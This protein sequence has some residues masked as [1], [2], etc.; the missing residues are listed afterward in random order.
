MVTLENLYTSD[1]DKILKHLNGEEVS[2][3]I[4]WETSDKKIVKINENGEFKCYSY[5]C[6]SYERCK[7][8]IWCS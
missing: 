4:E 2:K 3:N 5:K 8:P 6:K 1:M 7:G